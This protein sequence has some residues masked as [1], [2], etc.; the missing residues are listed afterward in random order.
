MTMS[1]SGSELPLGLYDT[2][3]D[4]DLRQRLQLLVSRHVIPDINAIDAAEIPDR[5][6]EMVG[7]WAKRI[8]A[9]Q[10]SEDRGEMASKLSRALLAI[11]RDLYPDASQAELAIGQEVSRLTAIEHLG[12]DGKPIPIARPHTPLRDTVLMTNARGQPS[13]VNEIFAEIESADR[14]DIIVAFVRWSGIRQIIEQLRRHVQ[15]GRSLRVITTTYTG[16]TEL[17]ALE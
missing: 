4:E 12:P 14:I 15:E 2:L 3:L 7:L 6:G 13:L 8:L 9:S 5:V 17:R 16:T 10:P 1:Q 11:L